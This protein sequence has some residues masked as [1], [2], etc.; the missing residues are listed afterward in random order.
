MGDVYENSKMGPFNQITLSKYL[1]GKKVARGFDV[2]NF[3][4]VLKGSSTVKDLPVLMEL[5]YTSFT[6]INPDPEGYSSYV[7]KYRPLFAN[8][9]KKPEFIFQ[10]ACDSTEFEG[11]KLMMPPTMSTL[12]DTNYDKTLNMLKEAL[13]NPADYTFIFTGNVDLESFE[14]L[15]LQYLGSLTTSAPSTV[16]VV[17]PIEMAK[18][19]VVNHFEQQMQTPA[20]YIKT[21]YSGYDMEYTT[22]NAVMINLLGQIL[23]NNYIETLRE[24]VGG[25]YSPF[26]Y[27]TYNNGLNCWTISSEVITNA[28]KQQEILDRSA[29]ELNNILTYG[30]DAVNFNKVKEAAVQQNEIQ[31]KNNRY[32]NTYLMIQNLYPEMHWLSEY[33]PA[34]LSITLEDFNAF[35]KTLNDKKNCIQIIMEGVSG[36]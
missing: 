18:G 5:I 22:K 28:E 19:D 4:T 21:T 17:T 3:S 10:Q 8:L 23:Q 1:A 29:L 35:I 20:T 30:V 34:L 31:K 6:N 25:T 9:E 13:S 32:W 15:M 14:N 2:N 11:N 16:T 33:E 27:A 7:E 36:E 26:A 24:E 12:V